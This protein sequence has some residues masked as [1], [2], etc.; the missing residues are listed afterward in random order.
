MRTVYADSLVVLNTAVDYLLLLST[1]KL[2]G[3]PL[4]RWRM[5]LGALW[6]GLY[7]LL[8]VVYPEYFALLSVKLISGALVVVIAFGFNR[9]TLRATVTFYAVSAAFAGTLYGVSCLAGQRLTHE[10]YLPVSPRMLALSFA[11]CYVVISLVFR[12]IGRRPERCLHQVEITLGERKTTLI[13]LED[14]GNE[15]IDPVTGGEVLIAAAPSLFPLLPDP[16]PL[17]DPDPLAALETLNAGER[18]P[19]FRLLPCGGVTAARALLLCFTPDALSVDGKTIR[20]AMAVA[21][22]PHAL[23]PDGEYQAIIRL[24]GN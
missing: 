24:G 5:G 18:K 2:C 4:R 6:G 12:H 8:A 7:A 20:R 23:A 17:G 1:G 15:L 21:V 19:R 13:A 14:S 3:A 9:S 22:S 11:L 16:G 10:L